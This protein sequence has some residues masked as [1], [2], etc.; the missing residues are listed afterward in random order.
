[1]LLFCLSGRKLDVSAHKS[2]WVP[3]VKVDSLCP[4][5]CLFL[6][7][8]GCPR[9]LASLSYCAH[10]RERA[11]QHTGR[12]KTMV[13]G[14]PAGHLDYHVPSQDFRAVSALAEA[15]G[16]LILADWLDFSRRRIMLRPQQRKGSTE[17]SGMGQQAC[18]A[19]GPARSGSRER[20]LGFCNLSFS[21]GKHE[22]RRG[23]VLVYSGYCNKL[24]YTEWL[25][26]QTFIS[27][28]SGGC[29]SKIRM[30]GQSVLVKIFFLVADGGLFLSPHT[31]WPGLASSPASSY[32]DVTLIHEDSTLMT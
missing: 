26:Q 27:H 14:K 17:P 8:P 20:T 19:A 5:L 1:M 12:D 7:V 28:S 18:L 13:G 22:G 9:T 24:P 6:P 31:A 2:E 32:K 30:P 16:S 4:A 21:S 23:P 3:E 29:K 11:A 25:K 10:V 15:R